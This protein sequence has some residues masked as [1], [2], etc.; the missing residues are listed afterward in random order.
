MRGKKKILTLEILDRQGLAN[1]R[2]VTEM[3]T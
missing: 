2:K 1:Y 3:F